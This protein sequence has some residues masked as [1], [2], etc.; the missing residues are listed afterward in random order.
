M[1]IFQT[2][3]EFRGFLKKI[4]IETEYKIYQIE[5]YLKI[6]LANQENFYRKRAEDLRRLNK[7]YEQVLEMIKEESI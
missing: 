4:N 3:T 6:C 2:I 7:I 5:R 1:E